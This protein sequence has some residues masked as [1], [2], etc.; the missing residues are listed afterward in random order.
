[1]PRNAEAKKLYDKEY[2]KRNY[3]RKLELNR[4]WREKTG[5]R[6]DKKKALAA[7]KKWQSENQEKVR[8]YRRSRHLKEV[9]GLSVDEYDY[10]LAS[11][12]G[13]C[14]AC[15]EEFVG[16]PHV[17]HCHATGRVRGILCGGCNI[18]LGH[19]KD[20]VERLKS[21]IGYLEIHQA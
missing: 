9:Y 18:A 5:Y 13:R 15:K 3:A 21:L 12:N 1:M 6:Y 17:D 10:I 19:A 4:L 14:G 20:D 2:N 7:T 8:S 11:Q 16:K